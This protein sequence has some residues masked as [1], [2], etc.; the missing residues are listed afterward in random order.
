MVFALFSPAWVFCAILFYQVFKILDEVSLKKHND[1]LNA[2]NNNKNPSKFANCCREFC[3]FIGL[4]YKMPIVLFGLLGMLFR[5]FAKRDKKMSHT[6]FYNQF[7][8]IT[9]E[10]FHF[11]KKTI[12]FCIHTFPRRSDLS[13]SHFDSSMSAGGCQ[14]E[15]NESSISKEI[16]DRIK[17]R[18]AK[19]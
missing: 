9:L 4:F 17:G 1:D 15:T 3:H 10:L 7:R 8:K 12:H 6:N 16:F 2:S 14:K 5:F 18:R 19:S 11:F 13:D